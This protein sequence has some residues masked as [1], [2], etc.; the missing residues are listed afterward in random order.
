MFIFRAISAA[1]RLIHAKYHTPKLTEEEIDGALARDAAARKLTNLNWSESIVDLL[2]LL[3][4]D[5]SF[6][7][8][9]HLWSELGCEGDY[10]GTA[11]QNRAMIKEV[12]RRFAAGELD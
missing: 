6:E 12:R 7:H 4:I 1:I 8:R 2:K 10:T 9:N 3:D 5:P 11:E